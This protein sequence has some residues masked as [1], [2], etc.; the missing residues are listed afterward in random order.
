MITRR[1]FMARVGSMFGFALIAC[2]IA[3]PSIARSKP[4]DIEDDDMVTE[5]F[6]S[7]THTW[8]SNQS[9]DW[10]LAANWSN[11][12]VPSANDTVIIEDGECRMKADDRID[13]VIVRGGKLDA[14]DDNKIGTLT[15]RRGA[16]TL[17]NDIEPFRVTC[18][19]RT[20]LDKLSIKKKP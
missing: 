18:A 17:G 1:R 7:R 14:H 2:D 20:E 19:P 15:I 10:S 11:N 13:H 12:V 9:N 6:V 4:F 5:T 8:K 16:V 3:L